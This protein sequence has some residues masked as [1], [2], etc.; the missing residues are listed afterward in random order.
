MDNNN[1]ETNLPGWLKQFA[2]KSHH[3]KI[4]YSDRAVTYNRCSSDKQDSIEWQAKITSGYVKQNDWTLIK[5]FGEKESATT[6]DRKEF[7]EMLIFC[8]KNNI[9]HI[10]FYSYDR[11]TRTGNTALLDKLRADGVKVHSATQAVDD[12]TPSGRLIQKFYL[13]FAQMDNEERTQKIIDGQRNKLRKGEW[14]GTPTIGY[15]KNY[16]TGKKEHDHDKPQCF[17]GPIGKLIKQA[18][19]WKYNENL[20]NEA[21]IQRLIP[22]GL[23]LSPPQLSRIFRNPFYCGYITHS[24][25][26]VGEIILGKHEPLISEAIF[27]AVNGILSRNK[28]GY[29]QVSQEHKMPFKATVKCGKCGRHFTA[30]FQKT[31]MYYKCPNKGCCI[32]ISEK[33][34][35][36]LFEKELSTF[37]IDTCLLPLIKDKLEATYWLLHKTEA[38]RVKPMKDELARLKNDLEKM[39]YNL[40][41][42]KITPELFQRVSESHQQKILAIAEELETLG[43]DTSNFEKLLDSTLKISCNLLKMW[44]LLSFE[45]KVRLQKLVFPNGLEYLPENHT[46]RTISVNPIFMEIASISKNLTSKIGEEE[47]P[48]NE[49]LRQLY[50]RFSSSNFFRENLVKMADLLTGLDKDVRLCLNPS[51]SAPVVSMTGSTEA[52]TFQWST[53]S[54]AMNCHVQGRSGAYF[55]KAGNFSGYSAGFSFH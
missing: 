49:L 23:T 5:P 16:S 51:I 44:Q 34:I 26:D 6:D 50:L 9:S 40:A 2:V 11:F 48:E 1:N 37:E 47:V 17:I 22:M 36:N 10:V 45:G 21:I 8:K 41:T 20:T 25:L 28:H 52:G 13:L 3:K 38:A 43:K 53:G 30:Y 33:K 29:K 18:F 24:L 19:L 12:E 35:L 31:Y 4:I 55:N 7:E 27:L 14:I 54:T 32:N 46:L 15:I 42:S 39:E